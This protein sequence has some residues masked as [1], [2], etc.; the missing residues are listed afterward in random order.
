[1]TLLKR[2]SARARRTIATISF[3]GYRRTD[4]LSQ[5]VLQEL[6]AGQER[7]LE[8]L[9]MLFNIALNYGGGPNRRGP[10]ARQWK[11]VCPRP[12]STSASSP[13]SSTR[14]A[15]RSRSADSHER[16]DAGQQLSLWQIA[17]AEIESPTRCGRLRAP[18]SSN[19]LAY[20]REIAL[21]RLTPGARAFHVVAEH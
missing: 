6:D 5:D 18:T 8:T 20:Q 17:Y 1:M 14:R 2:I 15:A 12:S 21:R 4:E 9:G 16:R 11:R 3:R 19:G 13:S 7:R 10:H